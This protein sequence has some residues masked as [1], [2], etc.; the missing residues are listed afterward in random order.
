MTVFPKTINSSGFRLI[1]VPDV[2]GCRD[3]RV[4]LRSPCAYYLNQEIKEIYGTVS[5]LAVHEVGFD[6]MCVCGINRNKCAK[7]DM[8]Q[9]APKTLMIVHICCVHILF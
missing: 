2:D 4:W 3:G 5:V 9:T 6:M 7:D 1:N 8:C